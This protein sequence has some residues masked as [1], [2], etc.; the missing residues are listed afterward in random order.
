MTIE[1][2]V[3]TVTHVIVTR[4]IP[5][6]NG[7]LAVTCALAEIGAEVVS[8]IRVFN[9]IHVVGALMENGAAQAN[10]AELRRSDCISA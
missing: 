10:E 7:K 3:V 6:L 2:R 8:R 9:K 5:G 4:A 1:V